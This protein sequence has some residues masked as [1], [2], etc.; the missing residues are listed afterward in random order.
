[1]YNGPRRYRRL[2]VA[3][4]Q[5]LILHPPWA[6]ARRYECQSRGN[7]KYRMSLN[8]RI[9]SNDQRLCGY[10][11]SAIDCLSMMDFC[12]SFLDTRQ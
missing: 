6:R 3:A 2:T 5:L 10:M 1:M 12:L 11:T 4:W 9:A 8:A 7:A